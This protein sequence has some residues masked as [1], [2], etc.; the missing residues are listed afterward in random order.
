MNEGDFGAHLMISYASLIFCKTH[1][2][3]R[4]VLSLDFLIVLEGFA[5]AKTSKH[6][7]RN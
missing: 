7:L 5:H 4:Q 3:Y 6:W 2:L 1:L